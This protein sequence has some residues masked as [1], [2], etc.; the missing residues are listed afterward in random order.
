MSS[1]HG[2]A[3]KDVVDAEAIFLP[4]ILG[5]ALLGGFAW[6]TA[7]LQR[8]GLGQLFG[9]AA[10]AICLPYVIGVWWFLEVACS[11]WN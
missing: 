8:S 5:S 11:T 9:Y 1:D 10:V 4:L 6:G 3:C 7:G 2:G